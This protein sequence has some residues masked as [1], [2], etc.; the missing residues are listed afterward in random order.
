LLKSVQRCQPRF[1]ERF[2]FDTIDLLFDGL[3]LIAF[4]GLRVVR[5]INPG[6]VP[7]LDTIGFDP[8]VLAFTFCVS[9]L[10]SILFSAAPV[11]RAI[12]VDVNTSLKSGGRSTQSDGGFSGARHRLRS[13]LVVAEL[14]ISLLLLVGAGLLIRSFDRLQEVRPGC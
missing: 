13:L 9:I 11:S 10:T 1:G 14:A 2:V 4:S 5:A 8:T 6:N 12:R 3:D 7:R